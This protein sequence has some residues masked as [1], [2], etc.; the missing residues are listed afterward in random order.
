MN[1]LCKIFFVLLLL[2]TT[3][4]FAQLPTNIG[5]E[6]GSL[7]DWE[8][9]IGK[10]SLMGGDIMDEPTTLPYPGRFIVYGA[11]SKYEI[12]P[13]GDFPV[14]CPNGSKHSIKMGNDE[15]S[16]K[17][18]RVTYTF[19][20]PA[21]VLSY[22]LI[23]NYAVVLENPNHA[24]DQ[25]P[26]FSARVYNVSDGHYVSCPAFD[27]AASSAL[28]GFKLS[29]KTKLR[30]LPQG[31]TAPGSPV[32]YKDWSTA[33]INLKAYAGKKIRLEF[34]S[35]DCRPNG[36]FGYAYL[37]IDEEL[38]LRPISGNVFCNNQS[39]TTLNGP[40][41][42]AGYTW[43]KDNDFT[44]PGITGQSIT[45]PAVDKY[46]YAL[47]IT[48]YAE[49]GCEDTLYIALQELPE[50]FHLVVASKVYGCPGT[51]FDL[52][53]ATVTAG[54]SPMRFSYYK[55][56]EAGF[57]YLP[58]PDKVLVS[59][60]YWI[61]GTNEG[62]CTDILPVEVILTN[63]EISVTQPLPVRYPTKIDLS[64]TFTHVA[65]VTYTYF[66]DAA[67][68]IP[69]VDYSVNVTGTYYIK[70]TSQVPCSVVVPVKVVVN[71][72]PPYTIEASNV[73]TPNGDGINDNFSI[74][75]TGY[76]TLT[77]L[78]IFNRYGQLVFTTRSI[79]DYWTGNSGNSA[80]PNGTYY[81]IFE[82]TDDY[83][84]TKVK[85]ASSITIVR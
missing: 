40:T 84:H 6:S 30:T 29:E 56:D 41:G 4:V 39:V 9:S 42:F 57:E 69:M 23:F 37:D 22:S 38:S 26:L 1:L 85:Q 82:G 58:N 62:G 33:M 2:A 80:L 44:K 18:Q 36:H 55:K 31:G 79:N 66:T 64:T 12:D 53:G 21:N 50:P 16:G 51:G 61:R 76:V 77:L 54:S 7:S 52:T 35:Q 63:P 78:R 81:W 65:N 48:P 49:L 24:T 73:F 32:Y 67:T 60:T 5:F 83:F 17:M 59:G 43:Y 13:Y 75:T 28:P 14:L 68:T 47:R 71:P 34:T 27:F 72:P 15:A 8:K 70:A 74:K 3:T 46:K 11:G 19:D 25:Q 45:V 10:R 20:I